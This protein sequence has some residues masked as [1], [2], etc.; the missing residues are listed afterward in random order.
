MD[1]I[2]DSETD[3]TANQT[4][5]KRNLLGRWLGHRAKKKE[6]PAQASNQPAWIAPQASI[7]DSK[8][9]KSLCERIGD[10]FKSIG[11]YLVTW[12][13]T[14][15]LVYW[16]ILSAGTASDLIF[17]MASF[18]MS[19]NANVHGLILK[20]MSEDMATYITYLATTAY[21]ALPI[22]IVGL[23]VVQTVGHIKMWKLGGFWPKIWAVTFGI[24]AVI[25]LLM[26]FVT[27]SC[28]VLNV[29]FTM[30][31]IFVV[32]RADSAFIFAFGSLLY[33]FLG[34]PQERERLAEKESLLAGLR[35]EMDAKL[36]TLTAEK[37]TLLAD[38]RMEKER[39]AAS[40]IAEKATIL[41]DSTQEKESL[42]AKIDVQRDEIESLK[43][44]LTETQ[45]GFT[46][47]HRAV[48]KSEDAALEAYGETCISWLK[49][50]V[51]SADVETITRFTGLGTA[52]IKNAFRRGELKKAPNSKEDNPLILLS[53]LVPWLKNLMVSDRKT[54][55]D[56]PALRLINS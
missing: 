11:N 1:I 37:D 17:L 19:V 30:P 2:S 3:N 25:F 21:V 6:T 16:L 27:I 40:L 36:A 33:F 43:N 4:R 42:L 10:F 7:L 41:R 14:K 50:G 44:L 12:E 49:S 13:W 35:F 24:P 29:T 34:K 26:D 38:L 54:D 39:I 52:K 46:E 45:K 28:S 56:I 15:A 55:P 51:K 31:G 22:F 53:S 9:K 5:R 8:I 48:N 32:L 47:L 23:A 18:W 20:Y